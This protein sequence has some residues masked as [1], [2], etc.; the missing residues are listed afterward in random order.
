VNGAVGLP[1]PSFT[2][3]FQAEL[4]ASAPLEVEPIAGG[5]SNLSYKVTDARG[6]RFVV[7]RPPLG[8]VLATAHDVLREARILT[9]LSG[10]S[11]PVPPVRAACPDTSVVGA[12]FYVMDFV[13]G[14]IVRSADDADWMLTEAARRRSSQAVVD[15]LAAL[16]ALDVDDIGLGG[17]SRRDGYVERQLKRWQAQYLADAGTVE[18]ATADL[19]HDLYGRLQA[20]IPPQLATVLVHGDFR[21]DNCIVSE[22]GSVQA[23]LDWELCTLGDP[24][25]DLGLM[26]VY[27]SEATDPSPALMESPTVA[28]GFL[29]RAEVVDRYSER[30]PHNVSNI[31][32]FVALGYWKLAAVL[33]GVRSR[34]A[35]GVMGEPDTDL[36]ILGERIAYLARLGA[37]IARRNSIGGD[38]P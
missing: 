4:G 10:T 37:D 3:W 16:H 24:R 14:L 30:S 15:E 28:P 5:L 36:A 38:M 1:E 35:A 21:I 9:Q 11:L 25:A 6:A 8:Q 29:T 12:P 22:S 7:R 13:D 27:W 17:L 20:G 32:Y 23:I 33:I 2:D 19:M 34:Y 26:L 31:D 18:E